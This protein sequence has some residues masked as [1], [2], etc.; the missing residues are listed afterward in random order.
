MKKKIIFIFI[1]FLLPFVF[2]ET[3][4]FDNPDDFFI[5]SSSSASVGSSGGGAYY[6]ECVND[7]DCKLGYFCLRGKCYLHE[8]ESDLDCDEEKA[9]WK[10][11]CVKLFDM[12]I[13]N[14]SSPVYPGEFFN[15]TYLVK[16]VSEISGDVVINF[17]LSK[18]GEIITEGFD[19][20]YIGDFEERYESSELFL[21]KDVLNGSYVFYAEV[22]YDSYYARAARLI[23]VAFPEELSEPV[24]GRRG[25][26]GGVI[27]ELGDVFS[28]IVFY[29]IFSILV[30]LLIFILY[31]RERKIEKWKKALEILKEKSENE[32]E[33]FDQDEFLKIK[34]AVERRERIKLFVMQVKSFFFGIVLFLKKMWN[35]I[36]GGEQGN[37]KRFFPLFNKRKRFRDDAIRRM[38]RQFRDYYD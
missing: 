26:T 21:P 14:I 16:G 35:K 8:C 1:L 19:T 9:C 28:S 13:V 3:T 10:G 18:D 25:I 11:L 5:M 31:R 27:S 7:S 24:S 29:I 4:F 22:F 23:E 2:A 17:W 15:F 36:V 12:K 32:L 34:S 38:D 33:V 30:L 6:A 20:I 37:K